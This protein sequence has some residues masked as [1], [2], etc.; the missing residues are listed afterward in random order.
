MCA[1]LALLAVVTLLAIAACTPNEPDPTPDT[2]THTEHNWGEW[3]TVKQPTC[4]EK[5]EV[6]RSCTECDAYESMSEKELGHTPDTKTEH[7]KSQA[8][9]T[10]EGVMEGNC[11]RCNQPTTRSI[12]A[13]GHK[14]AWV[15]DEE[16]HV[17]KCMRCN[18]QEDTPEQHTFDGDNRCTECG[19]T[20][21]ISKHYVLSEDGK[22]LTFGSYP[23]SKVQGNALESMLSAEISNKLP[24]A[25]NANGW[26]DYGYYIQGKVKSYMW[27]IDV[28][29]QGEKYRGVYFSEYRPQ[30]T[31]TGTGESSIKQD[32]NGFVTDTAYWFKF[33]PISWLILSQNDGQAFVVAE[34]ILD[35]REYAASGSNNYGTSG[36][37]KWLNDEFL[38]TA[39]ADSEEFVVVTN[40]DN[41]AESTG[42]ADNQNAC[43]NTDDKVFLLSYREV[44]NEDFGFDFATRK[45]QSTDYA[46]ARGVN[47]KSSGY[48]YWLLRSPS[49]DTTFDV[50]AVHTSGA[51][52]DERRTSETSCGID[53]AL[54]L[55]L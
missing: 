54:Y 15:I 43:D 7:V 14:M 16:T 5:G 31:G 45:L 20:K 44:S 22:T 9:C 23:Q 33:E 25:D 36:I 34:T 24:S 21:Q 52:E 40:V 41:S 39:F 18:Q 49:A 17:K 19:Y 10:A 2:P 48:G 42:V 37:R 26:I 12:S 55:V 32:D 8:T 50:R 29:Y 13:L 1:F 27:Y 38:K 53:P 51:V 47:K 3:K 35:S 6:R 46:K 28:E 4:T 30:N 11:V